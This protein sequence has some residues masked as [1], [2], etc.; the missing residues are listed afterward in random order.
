MLQCFNVILLLCYV[1]TLLYLFE[2]RI[3]YRT[4]EEANEEQKNNFLALSPAERFYS[5]LSLSEKIMQFP[6]KKVKKIDENF[7]INIGEHGKHLE[8]KH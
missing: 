4:K 3:L 6:G 1:V 2:M 8:R 7:I 5:F